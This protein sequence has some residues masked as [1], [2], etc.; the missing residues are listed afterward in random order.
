MPIGV[1]HANRNP[2]ISPQTDAMQPAGALACDN[3]RI[4][5]HRSTGALLQ[6]HE[7][8]ALIRFGNR[9]GTENRRQGA[10]TIS[11][12]H[13]ACACSRGMKLPP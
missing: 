11:E 6:E 7:N 12:E 10:R 2:A 5:R 13:G 3:S 9:N 8:V 4:S 1:R